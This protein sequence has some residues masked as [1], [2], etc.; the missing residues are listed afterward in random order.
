MTLRQRWRQISLANK[1]LVIF[2]GLVA[3]G[4][5]VYATTSIIQI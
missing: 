4:T 3:F 2:G 1:L 5:L